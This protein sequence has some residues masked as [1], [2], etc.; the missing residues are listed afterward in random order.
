MAA[1]GRP[2][3]NELAILKP[4]LPKLSPIMQKAVLADWKYPTS[5]ASGFNRQNLLIAR[6]LLIQAGYK[7]KEGQLYTPEGKPVKLSFSFS[8]MANKEH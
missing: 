7:I 2:S 4:L 1:T 3:N 6:Q 8:K 5:D